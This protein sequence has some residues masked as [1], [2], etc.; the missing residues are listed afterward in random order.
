LKL[1]AGYPQGFS[2][3]ISSTAIFDDPRDLWPGWR[4][5]RGKTTRFDREAPTAEDDR[6]EQRIARR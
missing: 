1:R 4:I 2:A 6:I 3:S 5:D